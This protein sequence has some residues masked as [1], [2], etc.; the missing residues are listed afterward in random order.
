M[1]FYKG[2]DSVLTAISQFKRF[3]AI[4]SFDVKKTACTY[5]LHRRFHLM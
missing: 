5:I 3:N 1:N 4:L 2:I